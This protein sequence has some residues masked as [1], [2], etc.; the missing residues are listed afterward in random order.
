[1]AVRKSDFEAVLVPA[2]A[3]AAARHADAAWAE[4]ILATELATVL[5][6]AG[7]Q[8][9]AEL[10]AALPNARR[11]AL[12]L[13]HLSADVG[14]DE[15]P[16][17]LHLLRSYAGPWS[18][19]LARAIVDR[20]RTMVRRPGR[21]GGGYWTGATLLR[22]AAL[23][24]PPSMLDEMAPGWSDQAKDWDRWKG[25]VDEFLATLQFRRDMLE[26]VRK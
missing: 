25:N 24:V 17:V 5:E 7:E 4:A 1:M 15:D 14:A 10:L 6:H 2:W 21:G 26:E 18:P 13:D 12:T 16:M 9:V 8:V 20:V 11:E 3:L 22:D 19:R 23:R